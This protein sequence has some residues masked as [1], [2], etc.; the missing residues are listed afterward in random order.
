[1]WLACG[2]VTLFIRSIS[3]NTIVNPVTKIAMMIINITILIIVTLNVYFLVTF[4]NKELCSLSKQNLE[5]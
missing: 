1:M 2:A 4:G 5:K 3:I